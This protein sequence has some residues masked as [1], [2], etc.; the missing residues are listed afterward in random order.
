MTSTGKSSSKV[1]RSFPRCSGY[2]LTA[3]A[4]MLVLAG[5]IRGADM[6]LMVRVADVDAGI[7]RLDRVLAM[8]SFDV[9]SMQQVFE[10]DSG[11]HY[12]IRNIRHTLVASISGR[13]FSIPS[14]NALR[15]IVSEIQADPEKRGPK[16]SKSGKDIIDNLTASL[17]A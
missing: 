4:L 12:E 3:L 1:S 17:S 7:L 6:E 16:F 9:T 8:Q 13:I 15:I 11:T 5:C 2:A 14:K 10:T